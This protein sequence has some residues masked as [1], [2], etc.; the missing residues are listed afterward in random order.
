MQRSTESTS[1]AIVDRAR[2]E[3]A[4]PIAKC[5]A[6]APLIH[7]GNGDRACAG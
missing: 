3:R 4:V 7:L 1:A 2:S 6:T 5:R